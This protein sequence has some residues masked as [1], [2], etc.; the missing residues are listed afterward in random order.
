MTAFAKRNKRVFCRAVFIS[1]IAMMGIKG[2]HGAADTLTVVLDQAKL[3]KL[4]ERATTIIIGNPLIADVSLQSGGLMVV[5]GKGYGKTNLI[6]LDRA[7]ATLLEKSIEVRAARDGV[8]VVYRGTERESYS[9]IPLCE[10]RNTLGD[11]PSFFDSTLAQSVGRS[12]QAQGSPPP[13][14]K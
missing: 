3:V 12:G 7:G 5:T 14:S 13:A 2:A 8:V 4:P 6:A 11:T 1:L 9:C 10:R